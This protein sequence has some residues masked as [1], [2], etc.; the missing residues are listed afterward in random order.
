MEYLITFLPKIASFLTAV[1]MFVSSFFTPLTDRIE[2]MESVT[3]IDNG[4]YVMDCQYDYDALD[5]LENG[6]DN[7]VQL[8]A[9]GIKTIF[10]GNNSFGCSTFNSVTKDGDYLLSRNFDYMDSPTLL[11]RTTPEDGYASLSTVSLYFVGYEFDSDFAADDTQTNILTLLA[12]YMCLDGI[13]EKGFAIGVL[14]LETDPTFQLSLKPNLTTTTMIR[15]CLDK[16]AN[17]DEAIEIFES[18]DMRDMLLD[19]CKYHFQLSDAT[20]KSAI[21]EYYK[22]K[23]YVLYPEVEE[24]NAVDYQA[25]TN[26]HLI[27]GADD[28]DGMG[29][30]RYDIIMQELS[31]TKG[32]TSEKEAMTILDKVHMKDLDLHGYICSTLWSNVFNMTDKT[33][34]M[35]YF[36]NYEKTYTFSVSEPLV[37]QIK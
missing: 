24:N 34:S 30:D 23:M 8:I 21:I 22:N 14:E 18:H 4:L 1:L 3:E 33:L 20:G 36:G 29:Y 2:T 16:A 35:C 11:V 12:P 27:E 26:F 13:N 19:G 37:D 6:I 9:G 28:P 32:V 5:M 10:V 15:T 7:A 31:K 25:A 17:V